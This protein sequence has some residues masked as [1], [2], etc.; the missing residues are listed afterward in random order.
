LFVIESSRP[1][2]KEK[3]NN[4]CSFSIEAVSE[5]DE[6]EGEPRAVAAR[7][8]SLPFV[9]AGWPFGGRSS[10]LKLVEG[11]RK[12]VAKPEAGTDA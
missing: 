8:A 10:S 5:E 12:K 1:D 2:A 7:V 9:S 4:K 11:C 3:V 6:G